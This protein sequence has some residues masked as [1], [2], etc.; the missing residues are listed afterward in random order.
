MSEIPYES[1][2]MSRAGC[3]NSHFAS[4]QPRRCQQCPNSDSPVSLASLLL[5]AQATLLITGRY[6]I[7]GM[8]KRVS[9]VDQVIDRLKLTRMVNFRS[10]NLVETL[11]CCNM[12][13]ISVK[14][15]RSRS[16]G[17]TAWA[18]DG[19]HW[20]RGAGLL[21]ASQTCSFDQVDSIQ[22]LKL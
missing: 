3:P 12:H 7:I 4:S 8:G 16:L 2:Q 19:S 14:F 15:V 17:L 5:A 10:S 18:V 1:F 9:I 21:S 22:N 13:A 20:R 11:D 6:F